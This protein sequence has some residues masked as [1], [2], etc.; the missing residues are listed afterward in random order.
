[1]TKTKRGLAESA[2][3]PVAT[4]QL[5]APPPTVPVPPSLFPSFQA[6]SLI[7]LLPR[8]PS[9]GRRAS[10]MKANLRRRPPPLPPAPAPAR[11]STPPWSSSPA[12]GAGT[13]QT[14]SDYLERPRSPSSP[15]H[16]FCRVKRG[17]SQWGAGI[18]FFLINSICMVSIPSKACKISKS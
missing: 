9:R 4:A 18:F 6:A 5:G 13:A 11:P 1:M 8:L 14:S 10:P 16:L 15:G 17:R 12:P 7:R 2:P 3:P